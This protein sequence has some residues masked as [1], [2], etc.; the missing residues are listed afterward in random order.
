MALFL[1][2]ILGFLQSY[3]AIRLEKVGYKT[4]VQ[5]IYKTYNQKAER[6]FKI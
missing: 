4:V 2:D 6:S 3:T 5:E 1:R